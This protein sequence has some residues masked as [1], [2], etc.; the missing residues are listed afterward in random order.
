M[1]TDSQTELTSRLVDAALLHVAFDGWSEETFKAACA[2]AEIDIAKAR[3]LF[4]RGAVELAIAFHKAGD[5][6]MV[7]RLNATDLSSHKFRDRIALAVRYRLEACSDKEAVRR[8]STLF[9]LPQYA[10][11]GAKLIWGTC[12]LIWSTLGDTSEDVNWYSKRATLSAVYGATVLYWLGDES[13]DTQPTWDFLDRRI[14]N[15]MQFEKFK[16]QVNANPLSKAL[17]AGPQ[18]MLSKI[19]APS[20]MGKTK[21]PGQ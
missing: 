10:G 6:A 4:P 16:S 15:V 5:A 11:D 8:G 3:L 13:Y 2:D 20:Q 19:K 21:L 7:E 12:D 1:M 18:W 17:F 14:E 9:S